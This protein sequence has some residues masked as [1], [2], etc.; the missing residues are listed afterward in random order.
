MK[1]AGVRAEETEQR[2]TIALGGQALQVVERHVRIGRLRQLLEQAREKRGQ[3]L[4]IPRLRRERVEV[5]QRRARLREAQL[6]ELGNRLA[7]FWGRGEQVHG[8]DDSRFIAFSATVLATTA[9]SPYS[10][11]AS[12]LEA[13][14]SART[15]ALSP[16]GGEGSFIRWPLRLSRRCGCGWRRPWA[17]RR[18]CRPRWSRCGRRTR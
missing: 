14:V 18:P 15:A 7:V 9:P 12:S 1:G 11:L 16:D 4:G 8:S 3:Q 17:G 5:G 10:A 13:S 2:D 6:L